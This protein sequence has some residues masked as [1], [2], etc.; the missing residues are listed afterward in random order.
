LPGPPPINL[1]DVRKDIVESFHK[2]GIQSS[3]E[4]I[5]SQM[6]PYRVPQH[7]QLDPKI[8]CWFTISWDN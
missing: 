4:L 7:E 2:R 8:V 5:E 1:E 6:A 3:E